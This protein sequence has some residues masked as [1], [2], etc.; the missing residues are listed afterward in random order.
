MIFAWVFLCFF[1]FVLFLLDSK[2]RLWLASDS[3]RHTVGIKLDLLTL[4]VRDK[5]FGL[6][7]DKNSVF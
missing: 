7:V 6:W 1:F 3:G 2:P 5:N 4:S